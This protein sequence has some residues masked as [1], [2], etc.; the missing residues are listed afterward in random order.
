MASYK[1]GHF[2]GSLSPTS[3]NRLLAKAPARLPARPQAARF[4]AAV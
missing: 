3:I 1:V 2:V 4:G